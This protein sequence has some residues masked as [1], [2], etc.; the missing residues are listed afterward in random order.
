MQLEAHL[1]RGQEPNL[2]INNL[3][4]EISKE[5]Q[6][7]NDSLMQISAFEEQA[8]KSSIIKL[9][10]ERRLEQ[11]SKEA[12]CHKATVEKQRLTLIELQS[13]NQSLE[14]RVLEAIQIRDQRKKFGCLNYAR[15]KL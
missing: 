3:D 7:K 6:K 1:M 14:N 10:L 5:E 9:G 15:K 13:E 8:A 12:N 2:D 4:A 11:A